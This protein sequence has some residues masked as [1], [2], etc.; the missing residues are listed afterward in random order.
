M[1]GSLGTTF[2][3]ESVADDQRRARNSPQFGLR[4][5][6]RMIYLDLDSSQQLEAHWL[7]DNDDTVVCVREARPC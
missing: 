2:G 4:R 3:T 7:A 1:A 5:R 6:E